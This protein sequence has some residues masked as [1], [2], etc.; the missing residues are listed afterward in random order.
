MELGAMTDAYRKLWAAVLEQAL[1]DMQVDVRSRKGNVRS[2]LSEGARAWF[3]SES[4]DI[5]S[6]LWTCS[7]LDLEPNFVRS[8]VSN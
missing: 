2:L 3:C 4:E 1:K 8:L 7:I 6:F 5:G